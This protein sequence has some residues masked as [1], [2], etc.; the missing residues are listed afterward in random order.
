L[1]CNQINDSN[2]RGV[3]VY[4]YDENELS[5]LISKEILG[6]LRMEFGMKTRKSKQA[7]F[8]VLRETRE[9]CPALL[10]ELGYLSNTSESEYIS[11]KENRKAVA[12]AILMSI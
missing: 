6:K 7:N 9:H 4:T 12:L 10:L 11:I 3:E 5:M 2:I 1:H 8:Q